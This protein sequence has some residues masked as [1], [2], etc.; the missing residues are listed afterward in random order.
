M[1]LLRSSPYVVIEALPE[2]AVIHVVRSGLPFGDAHTAQQEL[3]QWLPA[4]DG[5]DT[6]RFGVLLDF[7]ATPMTSDPDILRTVVT[8]VDRLA[9]LFSRRALL[10]TAALMGPQSERVTRAGAKLEPFCEE[11]AAWAHLRG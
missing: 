10:I 5:I 11:A 6:A 8:E 2:L 9:L 3:V 4:L 1:S 7:R